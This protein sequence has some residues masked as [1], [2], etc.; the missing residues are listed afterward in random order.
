MLPPC[1]LKA[2]HGPRESRKQGNRVRLANTMV[3][4]LGNLS[5][6]DSRKS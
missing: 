4:R 5:T 1:R 6:T 2:L 3:N